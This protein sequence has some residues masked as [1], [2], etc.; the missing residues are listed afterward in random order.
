KPFNPDYPDFFLKRVDEQQ[1]FDNL[2]DTSS[3]Y[4]ADPASH[5]VVVHLYFKGGKS[6]QQRAKEEKDAKEKRTT[7]GTWSPW[8]RVI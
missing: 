5:T 6:K 7:D 3:D 4:T 2:A 1:L 8:F